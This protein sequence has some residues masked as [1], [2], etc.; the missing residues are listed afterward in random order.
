MNLN[1]RGQWLSDPPVLLQCFVV[2][3]ILFL[4]H[5]PLAKQDGSKHRVFN[6]NTESACS[7][8]SKMGCDVYAGR[9]VVSLIG[10]VRLK[11]KSPFVH[12]KSLLE[13]QGFGT[14]ESCPAT[15]SILWYFQVDWLNLPVC[16]TEKWWD[17][18]TVFVR[19][20]EK[21]MHLFHLCNLFW[22]PVLKALAFYS[23]II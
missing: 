19:F 4:H 21:V 11:D 20:K 14:S 10:L 22:G 18:L 2:L 5:E 3:K 6:E 17:L 16:E 13:T 23:E 7:V 9:G 1:R 15:L 8:H 12:W